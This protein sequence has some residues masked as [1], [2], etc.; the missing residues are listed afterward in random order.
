MDSSY[1]VD[2]LDSDRAH[3]EGAVA[4][5]ESREEPLVTPALC[6][7]EVLRASAGA[8]EERFDRA[9]GL[10][11]TL[12]VLDLGLDAAIAAG[13]LDGD[14]AADGTQLTARDTL[15]A[16]LASRHGYTLLTRDRDFA[17]VPDLAVSFYEECR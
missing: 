4:W 13:I 14:L 2:V 8:G 3:N 9:V 12:T 10:L 11:R 6:A 7:F 15:V 5:M 17:D 1:L 16:S